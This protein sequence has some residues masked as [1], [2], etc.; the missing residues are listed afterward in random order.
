MACCLVFANPLSEYLN[1]CW[2][3][4]NSSLRKTNFSET[5]AKCIHFHWK[6][7]FQSYICEITVILSWP[8]YILICWFIWY[9]ISKECHLW[10]YFVDERCLG[11]YIYMF[12]WYKIAVIWRHICCI[13]MN[14][15][16]CFN[17]LENRQRPDLLM[18]L[19][20]YCAKW[21]RLHACWVTFVVK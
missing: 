12:K 15:R 20:T 7:A 11:R 10:Y 5:L 3:S 8:Q 16:A 9:D 1:Q 19:I 18:G 21:L 2:N 6:N 14:T 4:V 13:Q 17:S